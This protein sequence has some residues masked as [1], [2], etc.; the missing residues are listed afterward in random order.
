MQIL[1]PE[2]RGKLDPSD[3][4]LFYEMPRFVT[5]VDDGFIGQLTQLYRDRLSPKMRILDLMSSW[6]SHLPE[7]IQF[8]HVAGHG[9]NSAELER[10]PRFDHC[11]CQNLN[12]NPAL[13]F[14]DDT[15]DAVL[16]TVSIQYLE[17]PEAVIHEI[18]RILTPG[19]LCIISFSNRMFFQK[20]IQAWRDSSDRDRLALVQSYFE[21]NPQFESPELIESVSPVSNFLNMMGIAGADPFYAAIAHKRSAASR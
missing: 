13:P 11:F 10:N 19:G 8:A 21:Q 5:H 2:Q 20:A 3:D 16:I 1:K 18:G 14:E 12:K 6:V 9:M 7:E 4:A 17:Y 15:F